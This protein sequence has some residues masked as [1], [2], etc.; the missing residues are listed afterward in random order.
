MV[1]PTGWPDPLGTYAPRLTSPSCWLA[2]NTT[3]SP[4]SQSALNEE[5]NRNQCGGMFHDCFSY[6]IAQN[7][8]VVVGL[9]LFSFNLLATTRF[10]SPNDTILL[11]AHLDSV[12]EGPGINDNGSGSAALL[13]LAI[14]LAQY[15][16]NS[17]VRFAWW[18]EE[19][20]GLLGSYS[21]TKSTPQWE[22][23]NTRLYLN[24]DM[25]ASPNYK[26]ERHMREDSPGSRHAA[27]TFARFFKAQRQNYTTR[28]GGSR[29]DHQVFEWAGI[30]TSGL[31][32]GSRALK[33]AQLVDEFGGEVNKQFDRNYHT[34]NDTVANVNQTAL[35]IMAMAISNVVGTY[36]RSI[37]GFPERNFTDQVR[38]DEDDIMSMSEAERL[39]C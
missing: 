15:R 29:S 4:C 24:L 10:G 1:Y 35:E 32:T 18:T 31:S 34:I 14:A 8:S 28:L 9:Q 7:V 6:Y 21:Y 3:T 17:R 27:D 11:G 13:E 37:D 36:A 12:A 25:L 20:Q 5:Y 2:S 38:M 33:S 39:L 23:D 30:P 22:L 16:T 19:E 26:L